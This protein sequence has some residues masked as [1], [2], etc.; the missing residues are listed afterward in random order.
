MK[1]RKTL[2]A[3]LYMRLSNDDSLTGESNSIS[4]QRRLLQKT[5]DELGFTETREYVDDGYSGTDFNRPGF[6]KLEDDIEFGLVDA[7][8]VKDLS[9][10]GRNYLEV[11]YYTEV[12]FPNRGVRFVAVN[13]GV[14]SNSGTDDFA[15]FRNIINEWYSKDISSKIRAS[16]DFRSSMGRPLG[17]PLYGYKIDP[18]QKNHWLIDDGAAGIVKKIF[19]TYSEGK[20]MAGIPRFWDQR[21]Y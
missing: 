10:F 5:A 19:R 21:R 7:I 1:R 16:Y 18:D 12:Y 2:I 13:D 20:S 4:N 3:A 8:I 14:D 15:P 17:Q 9:R 6:K 11:G